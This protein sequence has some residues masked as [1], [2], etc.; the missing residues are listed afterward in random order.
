[1]AKKENRLNIYFSDKH[2]VDKVIKEY[3]ENVEHKGDLAKR[4]LYSY[5]ENN[6]IKN[7][8]E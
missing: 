4:I 2:F 5:I 1:M 6:A 3:F 7:R 8:T